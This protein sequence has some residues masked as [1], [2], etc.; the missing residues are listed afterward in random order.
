MSKR[1]GDIVI[2]L[3]RKTPSLGLQA[4]EDI[5]DIMRLQEGFSEE[6]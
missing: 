4:G 6:P 3:R 1:Q 5:N 2:L